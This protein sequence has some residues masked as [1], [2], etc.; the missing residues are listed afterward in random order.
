MAKTRID[1]EATHGDLIEQLLAQHE[2]VR[3]AIDK[4]AATKTAQS[5]QNAFDEL[6]ELLARHETAEEMIVRPLT[7]RTGKDGEEVAAA[8]FSEENDSKEVLAELEQL[9]IASEDFARK[10]EKFA[11]SVLEHALREEAYEFPLLR[12]HLDAETLESAEKQLLRAEETAP[13][14]PHPSAK[15]TAMNYVAGPFAA[16]VDRARDAI[17]KAIS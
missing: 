8:R 16:V 1:T 12:E 9:D 17:S 10:F 6:R 13:T 14:H 11:Q 15:S 3:T 4:V 5:R 7:R 2:L